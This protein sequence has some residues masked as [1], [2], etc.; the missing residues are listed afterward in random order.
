MIVERAVRRIKEGTFVVSLLSGLN[1]SWWVDAM[2][3]YTNMR[4]VTGLLFDGKTLYGRRFG[5]P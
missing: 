1:E 3:C 2:E 5:Q 4:N